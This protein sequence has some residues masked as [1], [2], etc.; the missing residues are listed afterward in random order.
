MFCK[1]TK[2]KNILK[3]KR[4]IKRKT[5]KKEATRIAEKIFS[6]DRRV[7]FSFFKPIILKI[8]KT[9]N[10][11]WRDSTKKNDF[12]RKISSFYNRKLTDKQIHF[13]C[14]LQSFFKLGRPIFMSRETLSNKNEIPWRTV[15]RYKKTLKE[16]KLIIE[17]DYDIRSGYNK[18]IILPWNPEID[19]LTKKMLNQIVTKEK[20]SYSFI[21]GEKIMY[22]NG[23]KLQKYQILSQILKQNK[24]K[25]VSPLPS[26]SV[27]PIQKKN[28][29]N[30]Q[31]NYDFLLVNFSNEI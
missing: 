25:K 28:P 15:C 14:Y 9:K 4:L 13:L 19:F 26:K 17:I 5:I 1:E 7:F 8:N 22:L 24:A 29:A 30:V 12:I 6:N 23:L 31:I 18:K 3:R 27:T 21:N 16:K 10:H 2:A 20:R 11:P